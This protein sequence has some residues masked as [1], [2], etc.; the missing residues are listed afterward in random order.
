M[1]AFLSTRPRSPAHLV[2]K[3]PRQREVTTLLAMGTV[4]LSTSCPK[5]FRRHRSSLPAE[6]KSLGSKGSGEQPQEGSSCKGQ[7]GQLSQRLLRTISC[8]AL[9]KAWGPDTGQGDC[10][11]C[12]LWAPS[13]LPGNAFQVALSLSV[14][15]PPR[16]PGVQGPGSQASRPLR[17]P[18]HPAPPHKDFSSQQT[19]CHTPALILSALQAP[20]VNCQTNSCLTKRCLCLPPPHPHMTK[21]EMEFTPRGGKAVAHLVLLLPPPSPPPPATFYTKLCLRQDGWAEAY[22][23][24]SPDYRE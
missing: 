14:A 11:L 7:R 4:L 2:S 10:F 19:G 15:I 6:G 24:P 5:R 16:G 17:T 21:V 1:P 20:Q 22:R 3:A 12:S 13:S 8:R 23:D 18:L 9:P